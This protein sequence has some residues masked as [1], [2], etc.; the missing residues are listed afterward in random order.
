M[1]YQFDLVEALNARDAGIAQVAGNNEQF[2]EIARAVARDIAKRK[3]YVT[4]DD[5]RR[6]CPLRPLHPNAYGA[7]FKKGFR[8]TGGF[9]RS[10]LAQGHGNLQRVWV[11][12]PETEAA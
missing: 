3:G 2:L 8:W 5:V 7:L 4:A 12:A 11:L 6:E 9:R 10:E 1:H